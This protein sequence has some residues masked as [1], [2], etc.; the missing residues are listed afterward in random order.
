MDLF[1]MFAGADSFHVRKLLEHARGLN[2]EQL[3]RPLRNPAHV[4]PWPL[5]RR[6]CAI[7]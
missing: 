2:D 5:P 4:F 3:D 6:A 7:W 1:D